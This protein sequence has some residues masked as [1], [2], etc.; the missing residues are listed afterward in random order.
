M[1]SMFGEQLETSL[2]SGYVPVG[3][4]LSTE[5]FQMGYPPFAASHDVSL[6]LVLQKWIDMLIREDWKIN[7]D[8]VVGEIDMFK[9]GDTEEHWGE[10]Q[11]FT[12]W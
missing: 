3:K 1:G 4:D 6:I 10:F 9:L 2:E 5:L 7:E 12:T 11:V 8:G